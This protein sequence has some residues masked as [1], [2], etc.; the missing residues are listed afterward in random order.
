[1]FYSDLV[2]SRMSLFIAEMYWGI[3]LL[4]PGNTFDEPIYTLMAK[5]MHENL[6]GLFFLIAA[7]IHASVIVLQK[8]ETP[9]ER[10]FSGFI[11]LVWCSCIVLMM[12]SGA[13]SAHIGGNF[14]IAAAAA[15]IL[16]RPFVEKRG[17]RLANQP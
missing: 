9:W 1:M 2:A 8:I 15:W 7:V 14:S 13:P 6:W 16:A 5:C 11:S 3:S 12:C 17:E 4:W 10:L